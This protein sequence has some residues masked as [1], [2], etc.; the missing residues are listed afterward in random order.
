MSSRLSAIQGLS[1]PSCGGGPRRRRHV[2]DRHR[3]WL[4]GAVRFRR[5]AGALL[6]AAPARERPGGLRAGA[7]DV[8]QAGVLGVA[9]PEVPGVEQPWAPGGLPD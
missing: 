9:L 7:L 3:H 1:S 4:D 5:L 8:A 2:A 6:H